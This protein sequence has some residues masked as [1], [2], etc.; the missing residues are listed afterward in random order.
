MKTLYSTR[1][2]VGKAMKAEL[3]RKF[4]GVKI[5][6]RGGKGTDYSSFDVTWDD[7]PTVRQVEEV[8]KKYELGHFD[9]MTDS[10]HYD[11]TH[12]VA[13]D[14]EI[15]TLGGVRY[16]ICHRHFSDAMRSV[17][18]SQAE[19]AGLLDSSRDP[20]HADPE[21]L[22]Y[23]ML[24]RSDLR[25]VSSPSLAFDEKHTWVFVEVSSAKPSGA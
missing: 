24:H 18:R 23:R 16:V 4:P 8:V 10:Y 9:G 7:G 25:G 22:L 13:E 6:V 12:V 2:E 3:K 20:H 19:A 1:N 5:S 11:A 15:M 14:G 17:C 21:T